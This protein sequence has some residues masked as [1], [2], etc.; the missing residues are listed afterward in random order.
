MRT[1]QEF[2]GRI[3]EAD[4]ALQA[5]T[6]VSLGTQNPRGSSAIIQIG[7]APAT[8]HAAPGDA[9]VVYNCF[10]DLAA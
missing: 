6:L 9:K 8:D 7:G 10:F 4:L 2:V 1:P 3:D 5:L